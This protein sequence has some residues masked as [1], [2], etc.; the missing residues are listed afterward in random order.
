M[1]FNQIKWW[2]AL[3]HVKRLCLHFKWGQKFIRVTKQRT[4]EY[5]HHDLQQIQ[6]C[7]VFSYHFA[8]PRTIIIYLSCV[9]QKDFHKHEWENKYFNSPWFGLFGSEIQFLFFF[10][11]FFSLFL[12]IPSLFATLLYFS[13]H[14]KAALFSR[15]FL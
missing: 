13:F 15:V 6:C 7:Y 1:L 14:I 8:F 9:K 3:L 11:F 5:Q 12:V 2:F 10:L 4:A